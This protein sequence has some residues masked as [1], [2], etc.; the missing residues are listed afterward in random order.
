VELLKPQKLQLATIGGSLIIRRIFMIDLVL[1]TLESLKKDTNFGIVFIN[2]QHSLMDEQVELL[3]KEFD[4]WEVVSIPATG[5]TL[6]EQ[7]DVVARMGQ[8]IGKI[9]PETGIDVTIVFASPVP[10]MLKEFSINSKHDGVFGLDYLYDV[11][12]F[13]ND[14]REKKELPN[15]KIIFTVAKTGWQLV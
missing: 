10:F 8:R 14:N 7:K 4:L 12:V 1:E 6:A 9:D 15:G 2:E 3:D 5:L 13:H 11:R